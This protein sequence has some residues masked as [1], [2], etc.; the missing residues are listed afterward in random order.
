MHELIKEEKEFWEVIKELKEDRQK[1]E[2]PL[3]VYTTT[4]LKE[5]LKRRKGKWFNGYLPIN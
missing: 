5:E 4:E 2:N 1:K 3:T